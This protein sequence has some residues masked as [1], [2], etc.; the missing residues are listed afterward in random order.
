MTVP[1][2]TILLEGWDYLAGTTNFNG[3]ITADGWVGS[4]AMTLI[5]GAFGGL[6]MRYGDLG[7]VGSGSAY[8]T[9]GK[10]YS[11][12]AIFGF[13]GRMKIDRN[14][15]SCG[16]GLYDAALGHQ[17]VLISFS[18]FGIVTATTPNKTYTSV[19]YAVLQNT[20]FYMSV[21]C[22]E[23]KFE[24]LL[25]GDIIFSDDNPGPMTTFDSMQFFSNAFGGN[26]SLIDT[27]DVYILDGG[28]DGIDYWGNVRVLPQLAVSN[29]D[30]IGLT[31]EPSTD[32][33]WQAAINV[34]LNNTVY[35]FTPT[36]GEYDLYH[37][38]PSVAARQIFAVGV[39]GFYT[40]DD[41][42]Q[43]WAKNRLNVSGV[44]YDGMERGLNSLNY[45]AQNDYW[46]LNPHTNV[47]WTESDLN[48]NLQ[49]GPLLARSE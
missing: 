10:Q 23:D 35:N 19:T 33:N 11:H 40:Q 16:L 17:P 5:P 1:G 48:E 27:D 39:K 8:R 21:K 31:P 18:Q 43:L 37:P 44:N 34:S 38:A 42:V 36:V 15:L 6:A 3:F 22:L 14:G 45:R 12:G 30:H 13:R 9:V 28:V 46:D 7:G 41:G 20:W 32:Q 25:N 49:M 29:G 47:A 2:S 24:V 26:Q 4:L